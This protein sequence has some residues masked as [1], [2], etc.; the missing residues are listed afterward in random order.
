MVEKLGFDKDT[1]HHEQ[2]TLFAK[3]GTTLRAFQKLDMKIDVE[4]YL[5]HVHDFPE[6]IHVFFFRYYIRHLW[7]C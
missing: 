6:V 1:V 7:H 3:Y 5:S 4:D 2:S